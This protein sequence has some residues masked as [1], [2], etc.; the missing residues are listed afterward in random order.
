MSFEQ[1]LRAGY[2]GAIK[3]RPYLDWLK[4]LPCHNCGAPPPSDPSH[5]NS[6]KGMGTKSADLLSLPQC[7]KCHEAYEHAGGDPDWWIR[8]AALYLLRAFWEGRLV[9]VA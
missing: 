7:R 6:L 2:V 9:W 4:T 3:C 8:Q 5:L 1:A